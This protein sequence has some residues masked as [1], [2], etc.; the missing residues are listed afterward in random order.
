VTT[1]SFDKKETS[2]DPRRREQAQTH[3]FDLKDQN[4]QV[5]TLFFNEDE[6]SDGH[7]RREQAHNA[8]SIPEDED[9]IKGLYICS[10]ATNIR[11]WT[12]FLET[13]LKF[14]IFIFL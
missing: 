11:D 3:A 12:E 7:R 9:R 14:H 1:F 4:Y 6:T 5:K 10:F 13:R 8:P 2:E